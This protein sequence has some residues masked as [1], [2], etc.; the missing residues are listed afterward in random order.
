MNATESQKRL[1]LLFSKMFGENNVIK[2]WPSS[3]N[4]G[5]WLRRIDNDIYVPRL[6]I[7]IGPFNIEEGRNTRVIDVCSK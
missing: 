4:A 6:D 3:K 5:D 1:Q 2:E 7:A